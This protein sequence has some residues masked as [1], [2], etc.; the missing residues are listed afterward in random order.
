MPNFVNLHT[1]FESLQLFVECGPTKLSERANAYVLYICY[2][3]ILAEKI[4][5]CIDQ[6]SN[7]LPCL[8]SVITGC[9]ATSL[10]MA[11]S[12]VFLSPSYRVR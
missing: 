5:F 8:M 7:M 1:V 12:E 6:F 3:G 10:Y 2:F 4:I 9:F 11:R